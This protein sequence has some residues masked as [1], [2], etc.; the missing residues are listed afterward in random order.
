MLCE[1]VAYQPTITLHIGYLSLSFCS[2]LE[3]GR[4]PKS[5]IRESQLPPFRIPNDQKRSGYRILR[6]G[7]GPKS[8]IQESQLPPFWIPNDQK[9]PDPG[10]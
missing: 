8:G 5:G 6:V 1:E 3:A 2:G 9:D 4:I 7:F 10:S